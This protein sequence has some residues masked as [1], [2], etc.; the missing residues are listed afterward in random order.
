MKPVPPI[1]CLSTSLDI[2][3]RWAPRG[4]RDSL[5]KHRY[6]FSRRNRERLLSGNVCRKRA[7]K[8]VSIDPRSGCCTADETGQLPGAS[9]SRDPS[10]DSD[11]R[12]PSNLQSRLRSALKVG[13]SRV[14]RVRHDIKTL[15][16]YF[17]EHTFRPVTRS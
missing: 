3:S 6:S 15:C 13:R 7:F 16:R 4:F 10:A 17:G 11:P 12:A 8:N 2:S 14:E 9:A 1:H 5:S